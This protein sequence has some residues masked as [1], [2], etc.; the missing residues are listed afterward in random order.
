MHEALACGLPVVACGVGG[1]P[2]MLA[3]PGLGTI[4][5]PRE[6]E[7]LAEALREALERDWDTAKL[8]A[9]AE[10][11]SYDRLRLKYE[12]VYRRVLEGRHQERSKNP[13]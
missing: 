9:A 5:E 13:A 10:P 3:D 8:T 11:Y 12:Q 6:P 2:E 4:C 7:H 1:I